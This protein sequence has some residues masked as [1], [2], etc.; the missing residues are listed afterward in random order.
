MS[1]VF[2]LIEQLG[3]PPG[4]LQLINGGKDTVDALLDH[5][6]VRAIS[7][8]WARRPLRSTCTAVPP[9]TVSV[10]SARAVPKIP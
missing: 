4:V 10:R 1:R 9:P 3:L 2:D 8:S 7:C 5:P 6:Q